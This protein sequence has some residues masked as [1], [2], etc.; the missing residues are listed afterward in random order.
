MSDLPLLPGRADAAATASAAGCLGLPP[1]R[2][3]RT[4]LTVAPLGFGGYRVHV[5]APLHRQALEE[6]LR[7][8]VQLIDTSTN[9]GDGG[10]ERLVGEVLAAQTAAGVV[11]RAATVVVTKIGYVQGEALALARRREYPEMVRYQDECWHCLHPTWLADQLA[12]SRA[13]LGLAT[14]D[15]VLLHN[16]EY[17]LVDRRNRAGGVDAA[18]RAEFDA[19]LRA[20]FASLEQAAA[21]GEIGWYGVSS[22]GF[23]AAADAPE[24]TELAG[25][26]R[27][28][29]E[30]GGEH[31][32]FAVAQLP[33]NLFERAALA[34]GAALDVAAAADLAVLANRPLNAFVADPPRMVRL[35]EVTGPKGQPRDP[36]PLLREVQ[37][38][39][40]AWT[41]G[42]GREAAAELGEPALTLFRWGQELT[43]GL[44]EIRDLQHWLHLRNGVIATHV[45]QVGHTLDARLT[46][47]PL[48][49]FRAWWSDYG[50]AMLAALDAIEDGFRARAQAGVD[51]VGDLL[52]PALPAG[53]RE[54]P[55]SQR[56]VLTLLGLPGPLSAVLVGMRRPAY[57]H[58]MAA[59]AAARPRP[60]DPDGTV[61]PA[62]LTAAMAPR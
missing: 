57:V 45:G 43:R 56:A 39:E 32:R 55:L 40:D 54:L 24:R 28:A 17:F 15:V 60:R 7:A 29:R 52:A 48:A 11:D 2:L 27:L 61:D 38:L 34:P 53:W 9:Y 14:V 46:G 26:L 58:D 30:V 10:S 62:R 50:A 12:A 23:A 44:A 21:R 20:A 13:R 25:M 41:R 37:R 3:G 51:R 4:G 16:P 8:G 5:D 36:A 31:H 1:R 22:N 33:L 47:A 19:R 18:A 42:P 59:L 6:A 49:A 35:A